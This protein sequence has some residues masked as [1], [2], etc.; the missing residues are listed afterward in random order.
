[1]VLFPKVRRKVV[2]PSVE[3]QRMEVFPL[4][5]Q[6]MEVYQ[7]VEDILVEVRNE[8]NDVLLVLLD[9][10]VEE[11]RKLPTLLGLFPYSSYASFS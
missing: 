4:E 2:F 7:M 8:Y 6:R 10:M 5:D 1:M 9:G 3:D 11:D